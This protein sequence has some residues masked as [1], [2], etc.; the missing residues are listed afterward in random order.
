MAPPN[1]KGASEVVAR[2][3]SAVSKHFSVTAEELPGDAIFGQPADLD[4]AGSYLWV[5]DL[6]NSAPWLHVLDTATGQVVRSL[7][8]VGE[9]PGE[10]KEVSNIFA[11]SPPDPSMWIW[12]GSEGRLT[13]LQ[14]DPAAAGANSQ[15]LVIK[16]AMAMISWVSPL[17]RSLFLGRRTSN[18][19]GHFVVF[20]P[21]GA[22]VR[23]DS[24]RIPLK[25]SVPL[26]A[27]R[28]AINGS[29]LCT[30]RDKAGFAIVYPYAARIQLFDSTAALLGN[31]Y[32]PEQGEESFV[33]DMAT[34]RFRFQ[35][36]KLYYRAC[37]YSQDML[38]VLYIGAQPKAGGVTPWYGRVIQVF[39]LQ[40]HF[41][42]RLTTTANLSALVADSSGGRLFAL[43]FENS[44]LYKIAVPPMR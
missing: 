16:P 22:I 33:R 30:R 14:P 31:A 6:V 9:G 24:L 29:A 2:S 11:A 1:A 36:G 28:E 37:A 19:A 32:V 27:I 40:G 43:S 12:D 17:G 5:H 7:G 15:T 42:G 44:K 10:F 39:D 38:F 35:P 25:D 13:K 34:G 18:L 41:L 8:R 4:I 3:D 26:R 20:T 23:T 21:A